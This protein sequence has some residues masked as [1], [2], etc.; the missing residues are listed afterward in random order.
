MNERETEDLVDARLRGC[1]YYLPGSGIVVEKQRSDSPLIQK[2][3][4]NASNKGGGVGK[5]K[6]L[7]HS[8]S[9]PNF[10]IVIECKAN[11]QRHVSTSR[12]QYSTYAVDGV[13][14]YASFLAKEFDV[15]AI[16]VSGQTEASYRISHFFQVR[17]T[18][19][20]VNFTGA[21]D[22]LTID[23]YYTAFLHSDEK[24]R[25]DYVALLDY[26][27]TLNNT[28]QAKKITEAQRG[29]LI[30]AILIALQNKSFKDTFHNRKTG[31]QIARNLLSTIHEEF[32]IASLPT[33]RR[34]N[35]VQAFSFIGDSPALMDRKF[36]VKLIEDI[37]TNVN[38]F[39]RTH[40]YYDTVGQFYVEF[41]RYANNDKGLGIVLT[42]RHVAELFSELGEV[43]RKSVVFDNC[44]G[45]A[46]LLIA[47][48]QVMIRDAGS[49][50]RAQQ[51]VRNQQLYGVEFQPSIYALAVS[52]MILHGDGKTNIYR[53][54]CFEVS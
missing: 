31:K 23:D 46:G 36:F 20:A 30:S 9:Q 22:I 27:R 48:M 51:R 8:S 24:F 42:P 16:A 25:Q 14:L 19:K 15:L 5:P 54:D 13:L 33:E 26:S 11:P 29:F 10:L 2:L 40:K 52:N 41:L 4:D 38:S 39:M 49:D 44:C 12:D 53:G 34:E 35:L 32:E 18:L 43:N 28:L 45:T 21:R 37:D 7:I 6:F 1:G 3:L 17:D 50:S 47:A